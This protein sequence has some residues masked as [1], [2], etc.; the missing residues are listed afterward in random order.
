M[1]GRYLQCMTHRG[2][3][4]TQFRQYTTDNAPERSR[5][6]LEQVQKA[7]GFVPNL[8]ATLAE[9]P[10][11]LEAYLTLDRLLSESTLSPQEHEPAPPASTHEQR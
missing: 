3:D 1:P 8:M 2:H 4:V 9:S 5:P 7:S 11:A 6:I 10:E